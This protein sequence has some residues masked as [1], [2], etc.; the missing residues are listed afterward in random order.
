MQIDEDDDVLSFDLTDSWKARRD[1]QKQNLQVTFQL[2]RPIRV[3]QIT[4]IVVLRAD[5]V[6]V[7]T[8]IADRRDHVIYFM[9]FL[10]RPVN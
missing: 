10:C 1:C 8:K 6:S 5:L 3:L 9:R 4:G 7:T 2:G